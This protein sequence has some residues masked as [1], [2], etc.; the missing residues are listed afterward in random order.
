MEKIKTGIKGFDSLV[1]GGLPKGSVVLLSGTPGT[2]KTIF[3]L[4][5]LY[6]GAEKFDER[7]I[8]VTFEEKSEDLKKQAMQFGWD[9]DKFERAGKIKIL[10]IPASS[11]TKNTVNEI[12]NIVNKF[13]VHRLVIDSI[14]SLSINIPSVSARQDE[15]AVGKFIYYF[16]GNIKKLKE[17]TTLIISQALAGGVFSRDTVSEFVC[18][19]ILH[20]THEPMG[21]EFSRSLVIRKM[22]KI[23]NDEDVHPLEIGKSGIIV[24]TLK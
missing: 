20:I 8:Y 10:E 17:T 23:K 22:R 1:E 21:G 4:E 18:D 5:Y 12:I 9:I 16:I 11:I 13:K 3:A 2:G 14:S 19:G 24:H 15:F 7:G 6:N